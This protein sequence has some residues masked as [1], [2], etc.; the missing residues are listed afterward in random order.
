MAGCVVARWLNL[1]STGGAQAAGDGVDGE[2]QFRED[3]VGGEGVAGADGGAPALEQM[4]LLAMEGPQRGSTQGEGPA[5]LRAVSDDLRS[6][7]ALEALVGAVPLGFN[8]GPEAVA[9]GGVEDE[10]GVLA[11]DVEVAAGER[12]LDVGE[13]IAEERRGAEVLLEAGDVGIG[14]CCEGGACA[15]PTREVVAGLSP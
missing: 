15:V 6:P 11:H 14:E 7:E 9:D 5:K 10:L 8:A 4:D 1:S 3:G 12:G 13:E 2:E